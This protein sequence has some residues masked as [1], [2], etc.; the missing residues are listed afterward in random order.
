MCS[1]STSTASGPPCSRT[2]ERLGFFRRPQL[3]ERGADGR[4]ALHLGEGKRRLLASLADQLESLLTEDPADPGLRRLFPPA[5]AE[6]PRLQA[7]WEAMLGDDLR[8]A[9][10]AQLDVL[11][12]TATR[13]DLDEAEVT[14]WMQA[15]NALRLVVGT[16]LDVSEDDLGPPDRDHPEAPA[17]ALYDFL[18]WLLERTVASLSA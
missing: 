14:A 11:R 17:Y 4:Y 3:L 6:D 16:R 9:R 12:S 13:T 5:H 15:V 18:G 8:S 7:E 10:R 1:G 2:A